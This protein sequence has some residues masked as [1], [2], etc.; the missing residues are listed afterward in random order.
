MK[1]K[2]LLNIFLIVFVSSFTILSCEEINL[3]APPHTPLVDG[4][5]WENYQMVVDKGAE[6]TYDTYHSKSP[7]VIKDGYTYKMWYT[8]DDNSNNR[9][10]YCESA[11]GKNWSNFQMVIEDTTPDNVESPTVIK[12]GGTYKMWYTKDSGTKTTWY[13]ESSDGINWNSHQMVVPDGSCTVGGYD[14]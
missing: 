13:C 1:N 14:T 8:G 7:C 5:N 10:I 3:F 11:D 6:G 4:I 2:I 9:I 12:D